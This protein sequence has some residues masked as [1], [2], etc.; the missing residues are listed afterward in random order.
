MDSGLTYEQR[1][2]KYQ[3]MFD[4]KTPS[5]I[6]YLAAETEQDMNSWVE[7]ICQVCSLKVYNN[8]YPQRK[9]FLFFGTVF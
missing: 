7:C 6:Y 8:D 4:I 1:K 5:R 2:L 3:F 9:L